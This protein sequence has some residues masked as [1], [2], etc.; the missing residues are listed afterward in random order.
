MYTVMSELA[1]NYDT[2]TTDSY[3]VKLHNKESKVLKKFVPQ[4]LE[5][6]FAEFEARY[7]FKPETPIIFDMLKRH[8]DFSVRTMGTMGLGALGV[9]FGP[10][11]M[12]DS[13]SARR[14]GT[15]NWAGTAHHEIAHVF[16]LQLSRGRTPRW[17]TE[18]LSSWE[19]VRRSPS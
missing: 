5:G 17:L 14:P 13:P 12:M 15:F 16:T 10:T 18:G 1:D 3:I 4:F 6:S 2:I 11:V 9:C 7:G 8:A 19:E